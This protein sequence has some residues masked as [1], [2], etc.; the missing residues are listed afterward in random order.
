MADLAAPLGRE[1]ASSASAAL[2]LAGV[3]AALFAASAALSALGAAT[4]QAWLAG[5]AL[6]LASTVGILALLAVGFALS[7]LRRGLRT[8][9]AAVVSRS[10]R[11]LIRS[12]SRLCATDR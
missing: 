1:P 11:S 3:A 12:P 7:E 2:P 4:A 9:S 10:S 5:A 8:R 6:L